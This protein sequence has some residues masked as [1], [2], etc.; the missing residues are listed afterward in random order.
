MIKGD[1]K[2]ND[3]IID[4]I[5]WDHTGKHKLNKKGLRVIDHTDETSDLPPRFRMGLPPELGHQVSGGVAEVSAFSLPSQRCVLASF[6]G[7]GW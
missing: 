5:F 2:L 3:K 1:N 7:L 6:A 4:R